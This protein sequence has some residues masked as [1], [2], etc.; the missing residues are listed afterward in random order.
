MSAR[1]MR[2]LATFRG[3][4][5]Q[6]LLERIQAEMPMQQGPMKQTQTEEDPFISYR[7]GPTGAQGL[8]TSPG[9]NTN[10]GYQQDIPTLTNPNTPG[11][12]TRPGAMG[13]EPIGG[14]DITTG[15]GGRAR[16]P[17][18]GLRAGSGGGISGPPQPRLPGPAPGPG[19]LSNPPHTGPIPW[20][21]KQLGLL[22]LF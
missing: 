17:I 2:L 12:I 8:A 10:A 5:R 19:D 21:K 13:P 14:T 15:T 1:L 22:G 4:A 11:Q 9:I 16:N 3:A 7:R 6:K 20:G 18:Q